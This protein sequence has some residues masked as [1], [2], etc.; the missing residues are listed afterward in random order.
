M[1][2]P[3]NDN[4]VILKYEN[5][6]VYLLLKKPFLAR[7]IMGM[8][9]NFNYKGST[10]AVG[11]RSSGIQL[12]IN[13]EFFC[14]FSTQ[15]AAGVLEHECLHVLH[16]H[17]ARFKDTFEERGRLFNFATD[18]CI[19]QMIEDM[20]KKFKVRDKE[21]NELIE[22]K[23]LYYEDFLEECPDLLPNESSEYYYN[24][25]Q[26]KIEEYEKKFGPGT[27]DHS[28][29]G[30]SDLTGDQQGK[31]L[32]RYV[33]A[34]KDS[35][36]H[37]DMAGIDSSIID[38]LLA[39]KIDWKSK[40][41]S[42]FCNAEE[43]LY[44]SSRKK[45]NKRYGIIH[46][47]QRTEPKLHIAVA[48]DT[49]G[50]MSEENL[51]QVFTEI[52]RIAGDNVVVTVIEADC[53]IQNSY[54][55]KKGMTVHPKGRGGTAYTPAFEFAATLGVDGL[56]YMGDMDSSDTP[57]KPMFP[58]LWAVVGPQDPPGNFGRVIRIE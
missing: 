40:L 55:Y 9:K 16:N 42:F 2:Q 7:L 35:C 36:S 3:S 19:N 11:I 18:V 47:G 20:P 38:G 22:T 25:F 43:V 34:I 31:F 50:S 39:S 37:G 58:V 13:P 5:A 30:N 15:E 48:V 46:P 29:W 4:N 27:D 33:K 6:L 44:E 32:R 54:V 24:K 57:N 21:K 14:Q 51:A 17:M 1:N 8:H 56:I 52:N 49:S 23:G 28:E 45:R 26:D 12:H 10:A 41:R 53:I